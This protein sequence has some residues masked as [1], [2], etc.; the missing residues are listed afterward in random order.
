[1]P[2]NSQR[3]QEAAVNKSGI[4]TMKIAIFGGYRRLFIAGPLQM[5]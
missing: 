5:N 1:M 3:L 4:K 2:G